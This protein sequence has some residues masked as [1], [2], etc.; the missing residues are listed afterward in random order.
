M[1]PARRLYVYVRTLY[2]ASRSRQKPVRNL[3]T[4]FALDF[5]PQ[6]YQILRKV[7]LGQVVINKNNPQLGYADFLPI[8]AHCVAT[9]HHAN[10]SEARTII[11]S[12]LRDMLILLW[13]FTQKEATDMIVEA[14]KNG[15]FIKM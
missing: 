8:I 2:L 14:R 6:K 5:N 9:I 15:H 12:E 7:A 4:E 3:V 10:N 11:P 13:F 1:E